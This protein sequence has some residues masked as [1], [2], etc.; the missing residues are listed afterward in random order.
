MIPCGVWLTVAATTRE[1]FKAASKENAKYVFVTGEHM[2]FGVW[3]ELLGESG[4]FG[5]YGHRKQ[6]K[7]GSQYVTLHHVEGVIQFMRIAPPWSRP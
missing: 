4:D 5:E 2:Y 7:R 1:E 3:A 6:T